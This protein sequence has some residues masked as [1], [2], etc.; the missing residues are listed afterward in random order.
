VENLRQDADENDSGLEEGS[1]TEDVGICSD[2]EDIRSNGQT[3]SEDSMHLR[4]LNVIYILF[5]CLG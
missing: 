1:E 4:F 2:E 5:F 3:A